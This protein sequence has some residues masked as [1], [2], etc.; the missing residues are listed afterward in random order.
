MPAD[1][2]G[3][4]VDVEEALEQ[5]GVLDLSPPTPTVSNYSGPLAGPSGISIA[6]NNRPALSRA[7]L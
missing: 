4:V 3:E 5:I 1:P 6:A 7:A 2:R